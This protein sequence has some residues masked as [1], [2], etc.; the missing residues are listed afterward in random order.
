MCR[1]RTK[2]RRRKRRK[3]RPSIEPNH[4]IDRDEGEKRK[5]KKQKRKKETKKNLLAVFEYVAKRRRRTPGVGCYS[6]CNVSRLDENLSSSSSSFFLL[7][8]LSL[9]LPS[10]A[11]SRVFLVQTHFYDRSHM[12][13]SLIHAEWCPKRFSIHLQW[14]RLFSISIAHDFDLFWFETGR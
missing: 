10:T 2:K 13:T 11:E 14:N 6:S 4:L 5:E 7:R 12:F 8:L 1:A 9:S 3:S